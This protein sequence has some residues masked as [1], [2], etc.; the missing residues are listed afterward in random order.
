MHLFFL[1]SWFNWCYNFSCR[2]FGLDFFSW[3]YNFCSRLNFLFNRCSSFWLYFI[4]WS[5]FFNWCRF[6]WSNNLFN[7]SNYFC[8]LDFFRSSTI[9]LSIIFVNW[10]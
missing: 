5:N 4:Y 8:F 9:W 1:N 7:W 3:C 6:S 2:F 10:F